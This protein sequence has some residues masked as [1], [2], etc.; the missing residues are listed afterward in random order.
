MKITNNSEA[1]QGINTVSGVVF[2]RP[3]ETRD[4]DVNDVESAL[5]RRHSFLSVE[6]EGTIEQFT[7]PGGK[8]EIA[9]LHDQVSAKDD[10][11]VA[12]KQGVVAKDDEIV[13]L[14]RD[15]AAKDDEIAKLK[16]EL[17]ATRGVDLTAGVVVSGGG[18]GANDADEHEPSSERD[19]LKKQAG[20]LGITFARNVT[21][22]KLRALID[23]KL[24]A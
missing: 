16:G 8:E 15:L 3:G 21:T 6:V 18:G 23:A 22:D 1:L 12:L 11:I 14:K 19:E 9:A 13:S 7:A 2:L 10:E 4:L 20:E 24:A 17:A 5:L